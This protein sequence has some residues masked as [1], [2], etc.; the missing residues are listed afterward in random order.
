MRYRNI[1][2]YS[3]FTVLLLPFVTIQLYAQSYTIET[4]LFT[5]KTEIV[6]GT[7][8]R[9]L[10]VF[11]D[12]LTINNNSD[13]IFDANL[14]DGSRGIILFS[15][16]EIKLVAQSVNDPSRTVGDFLWVGS[17][18]INDDGT[19]VFHASTMIDGDKSA[20]GLF[21]FENGIIAPIVSSGDLVQGLESHIEGLEFFIE[22]VGFG[23]RISLNNKGEVAFTATLSDE[24]GGLFVLTEEGIKPIL[25]EGD[26]FPVFSGNEILELISLPVI[27]DKGEI[28]FEGRFFESG[29]SP[30]LDNLFSGVFLFREGEILSVK[31]PRQEAPGTNGKVFRQQH[32]SWIALGNNSEVVYQGS[33]LKPD[34]KVT[35][36]FSGQGA[37]LYVWSEG[38]TRTLAVTGDRI[39]GVKGVYLGNPGVLTKNSINDSG[40]IVASVL[41]TRLGGLFLFSGEEVTPI[42]LAQDPPPEVRGLI[43]PG[44]AS[45]NDRG[46]IVFFGDDVL[47]FRRGLF[48]ATKK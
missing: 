3:L 19:V 32:S 18:D 46:D 29:K 45:I 33:F 16:G 24:R 31:L 41:T 7:G 47:R 39:P 37:G 12:N 26:P 11:G 36:R 38:E 43:L 27:N 10:S 48:L 6:P 15:D 20:S 13:F 44:T 2:L 34:K 5:R 14:S 23:G 28:V 30:T 17:P 9:V 1:V 21:K 22:R 4:I 35:D 25:I 40:E 8:L 42:V